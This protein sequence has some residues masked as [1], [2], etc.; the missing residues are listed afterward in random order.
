MLNT[1]PTPDMGR[2]FFLA[3]QATPNFS[4]SHKGSNLGFKTEFRGYPWL[5]TGYAIMANGDNFDLV[6]AISNAI[7]AVYRLP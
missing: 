6:T 3:Q 5:G 1:G 2:G 7:K 4:F